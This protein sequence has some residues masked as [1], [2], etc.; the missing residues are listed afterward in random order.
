[1]EEERR[2]LEHNQGEM[3][4]RLGQEMAGSAR[5]RA[6]ISAAQVRREIS[7]IRERCRTGW[8]RRWLAVLGSEQRSG[9]FPLNMMNVQFHW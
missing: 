4:D 6:E 3:Q 9:R 7:L 1:L 2:R 5:L 8:A